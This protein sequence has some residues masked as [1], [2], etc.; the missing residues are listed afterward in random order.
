MSRRKLIWHIGLA[1]APRPLLPANLATHTDALLAA[2]VQVVA[3]PE[4]A[5]LATHELLRTHRPAGL[6]RREVEGSWARISD[7]VWQHK[8]VSVLST[9]DLCV[10]DKDQVRLALDPLIGVEVHLV[11][12]LDSFSQQFYGGWLSSLRSGGTTGWE[13]YVA[14]VA[15]PSRSHEQADRFWSGHDVPA[16]LSRWGWTF[17]ADRLHV[18]APS[19]VEDQWFSFLS[20]LGVSS[21]G[22][23][24]VV[25]AYADPAGVAV[26]RRVN[27]QLEDPIGPGTVALL[28]SGDQAGSAMP[29]ADTGDLLPVATEWTAALAG[30]GH[31]LRGDLALLVDR[32]EGTSLPG[33]RDQLGVAV[34]ALADALADN[35][36]LR[37]TV[38]TLEASQERLKRKRRKLKR[39]L[40][41]AGSGRRSG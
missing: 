35:A 3:T 38:A 29:V 21:S 24:P 1:D 20:L 33:P 27:R 41:K 22:L 5:R 7:R 8:G 17:R 26:L 2:G 40:E 23:D 15:S 25:P 18:L 31:D 30:A 13:K 6:T 12:T 11:V 34:D 36:R 10:A 28:A 19:S 16:I 32:G 37:A 39:R 4:E 9:P 14:R